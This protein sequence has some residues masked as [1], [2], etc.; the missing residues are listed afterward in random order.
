METHRSS[1]ETI[2]ELNLEVVISTFRNQQLCFISNY[3]EHLPTMTRLFFFLIFF[4]SNFLFGQAEIL[5][6]SLLDPTYPVAYRG[7]ENRI[8]VTRYEEDSTVVLVCEKD[9][10][11]KRGDFYFYEGCKLKTDTLKA[12]KDGRIVAQ[13]SYLIEN[14]RQPKIYLG[15]IRDSLVTIEEICNN[16]AL[17][18][19]Y[20]P[21]I[22]LPC[23]RIVN[24]DGVIL[25]RDGKKI[26]L[27]KEEQKKNNW[28]SE[29][30]ERKRTEI[31]RKGGTIVNGTNQ[32][33]AYQMRQIKKMKAGDVLHIQN[34]TLSC[35]TCAYKKIVVNLRFTIK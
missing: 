18:V 20:E 1:F 30:R 14:L 13:K 19:S 34:G 17:I 11:K 6:K 9:T 4:Q 28:Y 5:N 23:L 35:P 16:T 26:P 7:F 10:I 27:V 21:Q 8:V 32:F 24:F 29:K 22:A 2:W 15:T 33:N 12:I 31:E 3:F 25:K